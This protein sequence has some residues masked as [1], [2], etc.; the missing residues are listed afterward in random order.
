MSYD[1]IL[2]RSPSIIYQ[3]GGVAGGLVVTSWSQVQKYITARQGACIVYIDDSIT[4]PAPIPSATGVTE[5]FGRVE[6]RPF[7]E[8]SIN[9]VTLQIENGATADVQIFAD[10]LRASR[11]GVMFPRARG[12]T[13]S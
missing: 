4:S 11:R 1:A 8:D 12:S 3:P 5:C 10:F 6:L 2:A 7:E 9:F 13:E